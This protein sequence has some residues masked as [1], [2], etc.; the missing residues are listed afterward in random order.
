MRSFKRKRGYITIAQNSSSGDYLRMAYALALSL[1][2]TQTEVSHLSVCVTPG[3]EI[4]DAYKSAF[5]EIIELPWKDRAEGENWKIH[6]KWKVFHVTPYEETILVDAD[7]LF[8]KD[9]NNAWEILKR[10]DAWM[11]TQPMTYRGAIIEPGYYRWDF[12]NNKLPNVYTAFFYFKHRQEVHDYFDTVR[13]VY[14]NWEEL[15][16]RYACRDMDENVL[17]YLHQ[18]N[19]RLAHEWYHFFQYFP[20]HVSG[21]LAFAIA[22]KIMGREKEYTASHRFPTFVHMKIMDQGLKTQIPD[23]NW[24][25]I[26]PW[27][28]SD[29]LTLMV[30]GH[31]QRAPFHYHVKSFLSDE[32]IHKLEARQ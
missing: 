17:N 7:T 19:H 29:D 24:D 22:M 20:T 26:L 12:I 9:V 16:H 1:K 3:Q 10:R 30:A 4:P 32:V 15:R 18:N 11:A 13:R 5:D 6:N 25:E 27:S 21:D 23:V 2:A 14:L 28:L 31:I 8:T